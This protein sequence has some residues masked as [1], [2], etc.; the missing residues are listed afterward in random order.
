MTQ[1]IDISK[2][3][4]KGFFF[5]VLPVYQ[6]FHVLDGEN[7]ISIKKTAKRFLCAT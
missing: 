7:S 4:C 6:K 1:T 5:H 3:T 2:F